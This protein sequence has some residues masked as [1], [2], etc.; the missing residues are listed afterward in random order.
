MGVSMVASNYGGSNRYQSK[1][2]EATYFLLRMNQR[3]DDRVVFGYYLSAFLSSSRSVLQYACDP[4]RKTP[5]QTWYENGVASSKVFLFFRDKRNVEIHDNPLPLNAHINVGI[6]R[7]S[8]SESVSV[9]I[10]R[11]DGSEEVDT[12]EE[13]T[14]VSESTGNDSWSITY[15]FGD[16]SGSEDALSLCNLYLIELKQF[17]VNGFQDGHFS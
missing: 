5:G 9:S 15:A 7:M 1:L 17:V 13:A 14:P 3:T 2:D 6:S 12:G 8:I 10:V 4:T 16:W 11:G